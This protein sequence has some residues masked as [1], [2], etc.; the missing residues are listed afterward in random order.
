[1]TYAIRRDNGD[2]LWFDAI[3]DVAEDYRATVSKHPL[4][5]GSFVSDHTTVDNKKFFIRGILS[6]ADFNLNRPSDEGWRSVTD[7]QYVNNTETAKPV[8]IT[9]EGARWRSF[10]PEV[11]SQFTASTIPT[12][13]VTPQAKVKTAHAVRSDLIQILEDREPFTLVEYNSNLVARSWSNVVMT[14]LT[15]EEDADTG[16]GL[17]PSMQME[18]VVYTDQLAITIAIR[19]NKGRQSGVKSDKAMGKGDD[20][21]NEK[22]S[23]A[24]KSAA[25]VSPYAYNRS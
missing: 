19:S 25:D 18:Q 5:S 16:E 12:V 15:F 21:A 1:M 23:N 8:V 10:I 2:V 6:D 11:V 24:N 13:T 22:T 7:K 9:Q 3:T 17:F 4:S 14:G 20:A